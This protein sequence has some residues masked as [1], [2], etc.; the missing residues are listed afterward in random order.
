MTR[1]Q[2]SDFDQ[3]LLD[4]FDHYVHGRIDRAVLFF[5]AM[6]ACQR[7]PNVRAFYEKLVARGKTKRS[8]QTAVM[9]KLL[10]SIWGILEHRQPW[11]GAKFY[12]LPE[13]DG[14]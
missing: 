5:P 4:L 13:P 3:G 10:L 11:D 12:R 14:A 9:R 2:A 6:V 7:D 1:K 8:A